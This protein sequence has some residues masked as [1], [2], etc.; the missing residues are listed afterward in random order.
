MT[1]DYIAVAAAWDHRVAYRRVCVRGGGGGG[2]G[3]GAN[4]DSPPA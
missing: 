1:D 3:G 2:G 4:W